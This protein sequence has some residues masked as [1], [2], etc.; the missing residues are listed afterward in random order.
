MEEIFRCF[1]RVEP[2]AYVDRMSEYRGRMVGGGKINEEI[3]KLGRL[4]GG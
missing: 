2:K 1:G 3:K 4:C